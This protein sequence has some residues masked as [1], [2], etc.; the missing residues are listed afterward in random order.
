MAEI[1]E[2]LTELVEDVVTKCASTSKPYN[3]SFVVSM[4]RMIGDKDNSSFIKPIQTAI[5]NAVKQVKAQQR[6]R[7]KEACNNCHAASVEREKYR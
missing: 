7:V 6:E 1:Q 2:I 3:Q 4:I 5:A